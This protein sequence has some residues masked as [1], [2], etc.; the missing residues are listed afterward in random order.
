MQTD[1]VLLVILTC[2]NNAGEVSALPN[3][4]FC[5]KA[6]QGSMCIPHLVLVALRMAGMGTD[7]KPPT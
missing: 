1:P 3:T 6:A 5:Y 4:Q 7:C 2:D